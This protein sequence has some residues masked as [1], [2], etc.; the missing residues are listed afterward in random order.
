MPLNSEIGTL[1]IKCKKEDNSCFCCQRY[2]T[3]TEIMMLQLEGGR[4][5]QGEG[6][7]LRS[8]RGAEETVS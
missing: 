1:L 5:H 3:S 8:P 7:Q 6:E 2:G 4:D